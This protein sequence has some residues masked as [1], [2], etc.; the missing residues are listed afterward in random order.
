RLANARNC[1]ILFMAGGD[2]VSHRRGRA[3][4]P[5][6]HRELCR[7]RQ[8]TRCAVHPPTGHFG[9]RRPCSCRIAGGSLGRGWRAVAQFLRTRCVGGP[10]KKDGIS[11]DLP[12]RTGGGVREISARSR[13]RPVPAGPFFLPKGG[14]CL[15]TGSRTTSHLR[16]RVPEVLP[17]TNGRL[18]SI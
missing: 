17:P 8:R 4:N 15:K 2:T 12:L 5:W 9:R 13:R 16:I 10:S 14:G 1:G 6:R 7:I 11:A 18:G 3:Q